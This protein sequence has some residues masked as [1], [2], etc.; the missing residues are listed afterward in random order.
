MKRKDFYR[1]YYRITNRR[2]ADKTVWDSESRER[3]W[4]KRQFYISK[5][6]RKRYIVYQYLFL[7]LCLLPLFSDRNIW[8]IVPLVIGFSILQ[9]YNTDFSIIRI[10]M[11]Y[12]IYRR[13]D[14]YCS[15][16]YDMFRNRLGDFREELRMATKM[17]S[18]GYVL[19]RGGRFY[20]KYR[21]WC[22]DP[23]QNITFVLKRNKVSVNVNG[24]VTDITDKTLSREQ[25]I[26]RMAEIINTV[27]RDGGQ[28]NA[29]S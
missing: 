1:E 25:L 20:G 11:L 12:S 21:A 22:R 13:N 29:T 26:S 8:L 17:V 2:F 6:E 15:L 28:T 18:G 19:E 7:L 3:A 24:A 5:R 23:K 10:E 14:C 4:Q 16:L 27:K 9:S